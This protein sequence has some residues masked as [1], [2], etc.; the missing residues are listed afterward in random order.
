MAHVTSLIKKLA[1]P[2][3]HSLCK[4]SP[5]P[6][7]MSDGMDLSTVAISG[8]V[9]RFFGAWDDYHNGRP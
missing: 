8:G 3:G 2:T 5:G 1:L 6:A 9:T 7:N 4:T